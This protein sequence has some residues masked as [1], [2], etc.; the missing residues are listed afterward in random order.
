MKIKEAGEK[1]NEAL[2]GAAAKVERQG[3]TKWVLVALIVVLVIAVGLWFSKAR[4]T[5]YENGFDGASAIAGAAAG[6]AA[7]AIAGGGSA[8]S[9]SVSVGGSSTSVNTRAY[10][11]GSTGLTSTAPCLGSFGALFNLASGTYVEKGCVIRHYAAQCADD[12]CRSAMRCIDPDLP[13]EAKSVFG[14]K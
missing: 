13:P 5:G 8:T 6:A 7:G 14:C 4:A 2:Q 11:G 3:L 9:G 12:K 10:S 1:V